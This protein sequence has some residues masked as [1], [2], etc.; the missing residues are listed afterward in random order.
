MTK[1]LTPLEIET[2]LRSTYHDR[3]PRI[4]DA[5]KALPD[6]VDPALAARAALSLIG[7][8]HHSTWLFARTCRRLPVPVIHAVLDLLE[9]QRRPHAFFLREYV[10]RD[11]G[12]DALAAEWAEALQ[13]LLDLETTYAWGSK[14][15]RAK[16]QALAEAPRV[17]QALQTAAV[18][19]EAVSLDLLAVLASDASEASLDALI[20]HVERAVRQ[21][22]WELDRL[23]LLHTHARSTPVMEDLFSRMQELIA[24]RQARSPALELAR[25]LGFGELDAFWFR[26]H[27]SSAASERLPAYRY[28]AHLSVDSRAAECFSVTVTDAT[29][30]GVLPSQGTS[31]TSAQVRRDTL[32]LGTCEPAGLPAWLG[33]VAERFHIQWSFD[34]MSLTTSLRGKKRA[35]LERWLRG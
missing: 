27:L 28:Q 15:K 17:L 1:R 11:L 18:A 26:A 3:S 5:L 22:D 34:T 31:F 29:P 10:R 23:Q 14:Q 20:P 33:S 13:A 25:A 16:F 4:L 12:A 24:A 19:C 8:S 6:D 35:Q 7:D 32:E 2:A 21:Q 9:S 30:V